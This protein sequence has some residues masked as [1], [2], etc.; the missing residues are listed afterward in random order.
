[1]PPLTYDAD[2]DILQ[3]LVRWVEKDVPP[4]RITAVHYTNNNVSEGVDFTRPIC[5]VSPFGFN[6]LESY[7]GIQYS[8]CATLFCILHLYVYS[9]PLVLVMFRADQKIVLASCVYEIT[10]HMHCIDV[11]RVYTI[12]Q[13]IIQ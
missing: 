1:M 3:A 13:V 11:P 9:T 10:V 12:L 6:H 4:E 2:H 8:F 7:F 5:K